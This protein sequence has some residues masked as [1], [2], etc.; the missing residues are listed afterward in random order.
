MVR[1]CQN[2]VVLHLKRHR[3]GS[4]GPFEPQNLWPPSIA[5]IVSEGIK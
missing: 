2:D 1:N 4:F 3:F 5:G